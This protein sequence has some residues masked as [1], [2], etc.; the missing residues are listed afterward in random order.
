MRQKK[1]IKNIALDRVLYLYNSL[2]NSSEWDETI[3]IDLIERIGRRADLT[4]PSHIK[5]AYCHSCKRLYREN[6]RVRLRDGLIKITC[7]YCGDIRRIKY[8]R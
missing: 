7:P 8:R 1:E 2:E 3:R 5:R 6:A 4:L